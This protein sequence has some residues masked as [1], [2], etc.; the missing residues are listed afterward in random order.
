MNA[1][2]SPG[3]VEAKL[4]ELR[5]ELRQDAHVAAAVERLLADV[6]GAQDE[7]PAE[8]LDLMLTLLVDEALRGV[9]ITRRYP[10]LYRALTRN[11]ELHR[12]FVESVELLTASRDVNWNPMPDRPEVELDFLAAVGPLPQVEQLEGRRWRVSW[13]AKVEELQHLLGLGGLR[14]AY[15]GDA[16]VWDED[17]GR[18]TLLRSDAIVAGQELDVLLEM[19]EPGEGEESRPLFLT[20]TRADAQSAWPVLD[21]SIRWGGYR[22]AA[23]LEEEGITQLP[24][25]TADEIF[26]PQR[27]GLLGDLLLMLEVA[28]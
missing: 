8:E 27:G 17:G 6:T 25:A 22:G 10:Q 18:R 21:A 2:R 9:D 19:Q 5:R 1:D 7:Q 28:A 13:R 14:P 26:D 23:R 16:D 15:R 20:V 3:W 4:A 11:P 24:P 12:E